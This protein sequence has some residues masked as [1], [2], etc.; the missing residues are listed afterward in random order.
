MQASSMLSW[1]FPSRQSQR[2]PI[3][4]PPKEEN[5]K[6]E[7]VEGL[8]RSIKKIDSLN[9]VLSEFGNTMKKICERTLQLTEEINEYEQYFTTHNIMF[10]I[11]I[12][13]QDNFA[14]LGLNGISS[15]ISQFGEIETDQVFDI[16]EEFIEKLNK[17]KTHEYGF[18]EEYKVKFVNLFIE[19]KDKKCLISSKWLLHYQSPEAQELMKKVAE[20]NNPTNG[21]N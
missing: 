6:D 9:Y 20:L 5:P 2:P 12:V 16:S 19:Q 10:K 3:V 21:D 8:D 17:M 1:L 15:F 4:K 18:T 7:I 13:T 14:V 11:S